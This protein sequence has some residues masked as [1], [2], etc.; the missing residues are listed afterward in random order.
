[1]SLFPLLLLNLSIFAILSGLVYF[2]HEYNHSWYLRVNRTK[3][4]FN[5]FYEKFILLEVKLP[6][7]VT[8]S[9]QAMEF[10]ID[11]FYQMAG[12]PKLSIKPEDNFFKRREKKKMYE[13][14]A[15]IQGQVRLW[16]TMEIESRGG[17]LHFYIG[18]T[19]RYKEIISSYIFSQYPGI[20]VTEVEDYTNKLRAVEHGGQHIPFT[21]H[22]ELNG[23]DYLPIKTYIDYGLDK[24]PKDEHKVDPII[25]L[26]ESMANI[27]P[28][29]HVWYQ[30]LVR[31]YQ[32][33][34]NDKGEDV[35]WRKDGEKRI[36]E[37]LG[38]T[39]D[40]KGKV[41]EQAKEITKLPPKEKL[42]LE[43]IHRNLEKLGFDTQIKMVYWAPKESGIRQ[44]G[45]Q[46]LR[47]AMKSFNS[48]QYNSFRL[49]NQNATNSFLDYP[50]K[51]REKNDKA[52]WTFLYITRNPLIVQT[53]LDATPFTTLIKKYKKLGF[54]TAKKFF[55]GDFLDYFKKLKDS[56]TVMDTSFVLNS[57]ELATIYHF[58][59]RAFTAPK[60]AR[61]ESVK[62]E[63]PANLPI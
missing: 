21:S 47:N 13:D 17:E 61:V 58:P 34:K 48:P 5:N 53:S 29:E 26:L 46:I 40:E 7:E 59:S 20:E 9:P 63:P 37:I 38:I 25:P 3:Y 39:R 28:D 19:K 55:Y 8:K 33:R 24:D 31:A 52:A 56:E 57:E 36:D 27:R 18:T 35:D 1:M 42:E 60:F 49:A 11:A 30:V 12:N 51:R 32:N 54:R 16:M 2:F 22:A 41:K 50:D 43:L 14:D 15:Y 45:D 6:R 44:E 62:S 4:V 10:V 23:K